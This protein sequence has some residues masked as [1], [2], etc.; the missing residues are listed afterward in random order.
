MISPPSRHQTRRTMHEI[1]QRSGR[2]LASSATRTMSV[3]V[4]TSRASGRTFGSNTS[5]SRS[6][7]RLPGARDITAAGQ[8]TIDADAEVAP[9]EC[10]HP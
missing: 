3:A 4:G 5:R 10:V 9:L 8:K 6:S 2:S 1:V 7:T